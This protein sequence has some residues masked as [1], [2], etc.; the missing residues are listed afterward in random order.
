MLY[1]CL[2]L[3]LLLLF[4]PEAVIHWLVLVMKN[5]ERGSSR[6]HESSDREQDSEQDVEGGRGE[7]FS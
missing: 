7:K 5:K 3:L 4:N 1:C 2:L 6:K